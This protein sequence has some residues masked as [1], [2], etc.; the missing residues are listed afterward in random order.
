MNDASAVKSATRVL[1][2]LEVL[3]VAAEPVGAS[4]LARRLGIPK[5]STH[6]LLSTLEGRG[7][8]VGDDTRRFRLNPML[9]SARRSWAGGARAAL[10]HLAREPMQRLA[11]ATGESAFLGVP[12]DESSF[13]Y[14]EKVVSGHEV[15][16]DAELGQR[17]ALH[18][19]SVGLV[20][21]AFN[22]PARVER[23]LTGHALER[24]TVRTVCD[25]ARLRRELAAIRKQGYAITRDT[26]AV[27]ASGIAAPIFD[28]SGRVL[29]GI[30]ISAPTSRFEAVVERAAT[31]LIGAARSITAELSGAEAAVA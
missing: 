7:Y 13:Q 8:V 9:A 26:N 31:E 10:R 24:V 21:L 29:A 19:S 15:R 25:P 11:R 18:S 2:V 16:C 20:L 17:R 5:S 1:D 27:G 3:A 28:G 30:N 12:R 14:V 22:A 4:E 23:Y 6:M